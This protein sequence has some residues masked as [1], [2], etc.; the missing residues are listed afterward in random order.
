MMNMPIAAIA[1][2]DAAQ[3]L[4]QSALPWAPVVPDPEPAEVRP[5]AYRTR[6]AVSVGLARIADAVAP[7]GWA[8]QHHT[9]S[10]R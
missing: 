9:A 8:P 1:A 7:K 2:R 6:A 10:S 4:A 3:N 5:R